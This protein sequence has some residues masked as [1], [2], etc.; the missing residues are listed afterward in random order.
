V[1]LGLTLVAAGWRLVPTALRWVLAGG[2]VLDLALGV[3][4]HF[5]FQHRHYPLVEFAPGIWTFPDTVTDIWSRGSQANLIIK[6]TFTIPFWGDLFAESLPV[7]QVALLVLFATF[8]WLALLRPA[9][10]RRMGVGRGRKNG[11][12]AGPR[13]PKRLSR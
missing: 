7:L 1:L 6:R 5:A 9:V 13:R 8:L 3:F 2:L 4:L 10:A 12:A 11:P